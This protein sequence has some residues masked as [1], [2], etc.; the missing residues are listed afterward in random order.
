MSDLPDII[1][2]EFFTA[3][4]QV[5]NLWASFEFYVDQLIWDVGHFNPHLGA[6]VTSQLMSVAPRFRALVVLAEQRGVPDDLIKELN[7]FSV[8][9]D[10]TGRKRHRYAHD[11]LFLAG[12]SL[13][14]ATEV[15]RLQLTADRKLIYRF[16]SIEVDEIK[17]V[18]LE[19]HQMNRDFV[20]LSTRVRGSLRALPRTFRW[21]QP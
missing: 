1:P 10:K 20:A 3:I 15:K 21:R 11:P 12:E 18:H 2:D 17:A 6:C 9:A 14:T 19:I 8:R 4:G 16:Q 13:E 7:Q 5:T